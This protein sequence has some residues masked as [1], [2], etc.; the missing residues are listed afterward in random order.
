[1]SDHTPVLESELDLKLLHRGK[2]RDVYE[3]DSQTLLM[4][5]SDR[6]SAFDV[7]LPQPIPF[8]GE[9]LTLVTA[10]WLEQLEKQG[11]GHHLIAVD[12][13]VD[14][15]NPAEILWALSTRLHPEKGV[16]VIP[17][18]H[19]HGMD[20]SLPEIGAAGTKIWQR[21][22]SKMMIDCTIPPPADAEARAM[23]E[24]IRPINPQLRIEDFAAADSM[25]IVR[26]LPDRFFGSKL[27]R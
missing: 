3:I 22:G 19:N 14:I 16:V 21:F 5:A 23:F 27:I 11:I 1:M 25:E 9:V 26:S 20:A 12:P 17:G 10:W 2:V 7:V 13:D 24:R 8:K 18:T 6:V 15:H 4:V